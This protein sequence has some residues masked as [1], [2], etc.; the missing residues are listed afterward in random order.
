M[1]TMT[2]VI[3]ELRKRNERLE[4]D[5][6][7]LVKKLNSL[8]GIPQTEKSQDLYKSR[9]HI[10]LEHSTKTS[11]RN[12]T[13]R[14]SRYQILGQKKDSNTRSR[15]HSNRTQERKYDTLNKKRGDVS[16][17]T[18]GRTA[19]HNIH[20]QSHPGFLN[21]NPFK[22]GNFSNDIGTLKSSPSRTSNDIPDL[23]LQQNSFLLSQ[24]DYD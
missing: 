11:T 17:D 9:E 18:V 22:N 19:S 10:S 21:S 8:N 20:R 6:D 14:R 2:T 3:A 13:L 7:V 23:K 5:S 12:S 4:V 1:D 16:L 24:T 15:E